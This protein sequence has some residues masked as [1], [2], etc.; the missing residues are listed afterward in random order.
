MTAELGQRAG[1]RSASPQHQIDTDAELGRSFCTVTARRSRRTAR[2]RGTAPRPRR[3]RRA[4][5]WGERAG[6]SPRRLA[7]GALAGGRGVWDALLGEADGERHRPVRSP[8]DAAV[9]SGGRGGAVG[10]ARPISTRSPSSIAGRALN[11][12]APGARSHPFATCSTACCVVSTASRPP[13]SSDSPSAKTLTAD[14][15][16]QV[17]SG[18]GK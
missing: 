3:S 18:Y 7:R 16:S 15:S 6:L 5:T 2:T 4:E 11:Q 9:P 8:V 12:R 14:A 17:P 1:V 10:P 13:I